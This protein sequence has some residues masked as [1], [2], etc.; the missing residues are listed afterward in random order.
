MN[1]TVKRYDKYKDTGVEWLGEIPEHWKINESKR[2]HKVI[3][4]INSKYQCDNVLSLTLRGVVRNNKDNPEGLVPKDYRT[5]QVFEKNDLVFKLIDLD[6]ISTSRVGLVF[7]RG[8]MSSAYI[9]LIPGSNFDSNYLYYYFYSLYIK[10]VYN[11]I[12]QGVRSTLNP[13]DLLRIPSLFPPLKEQAAI[14]NFLDSKCQK[15]DKAISQKEKLIELLK[16]RKQILIQNAVTR[17]LDPNIKMKDSGVEWIGE[18]PAHWDIVANRSIFSERNQPGEDNLPLLSVSIHSGVSS[19]ELSDEDNIRGRIKIEDK[20]SYK[21]V[22]IN[23][24][25]FNMMRA[26]QGAIG[27]VRINGMVSPAYIVSKPKSSINSE[28]FEFLYRTNSFIQQMNKSSKG[29]TDF[30]KRLYW[31][32]F[33]QLLTIKPPIKEQIEIVEFLQKQ[34]EKVFKTV[35]HALRQ[36]EKLKEYKSTLINSVVTG[37]IK[38]V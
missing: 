26:W 38:V 16:E 35:S 2:Y 19:E 21:K 7:E 11:N 9:R 27:V 17:G 4:E 32:E 15:I 12:G 23:D 36:I 5:Y 30:R 29:I 1:I 22:E 10:H 20:K 24:I 37:K 25:V 28:Y 34:N 33:K 3:K 13:S 8:I 6:N 18:I 31:D 14:A